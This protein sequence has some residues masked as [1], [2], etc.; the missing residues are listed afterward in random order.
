MKKHGDKYYSYAGPHRLSRHSLENRLGR[1]GFTEC[2]VLLI[3]LRWVCDDTPGMTEL[4]YIKE[5][6]SECLRNHDN[7]SDYFADLRTLRR[8]ICDDIILRRLKVR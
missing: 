3:F 2:G 8:E 4:I 5:K 7:H 6:I 1:Y